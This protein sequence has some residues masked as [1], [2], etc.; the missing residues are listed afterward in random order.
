M[1]G[2]LRVVFRSSIVEIGRSGMIVGFGIA[3]IAVVNGRAASGTLCDGLFHI[4]AD[5]S[6][7][8]DGEW[9]RRFQRLLLLFLFNLCNLFGVSHRLML[10]VGDRR[11]CWCR[12]WC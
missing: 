7:L 4:D 5:G 12:C 9:F 2:I 1:F 11:W 8:L 6:R 3:V 10:E